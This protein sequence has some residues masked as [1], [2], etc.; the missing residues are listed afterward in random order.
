MG[1][2]HH[3]PG[4]NEEE[5]LALDLDSEGDVYDDDEDDDE[6]DVEQEVAAFEHDLSTEWEVGPTAL[7]CTSG[8]VYREGTSLLHQTRCKL[9]AP[10]LVL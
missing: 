1:G 9:R 2:W 3:A 7:A 5:E 10:P 4:H 8:S 6:S